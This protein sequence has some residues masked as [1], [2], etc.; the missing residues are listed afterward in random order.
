MSA[1]SKRARREEQK[2]SPLVKI[3]VGAATGVVLFFTL[4]SAISLATLKA[5]LGNEIYLPSG[6]A[7]GA[8]SG[9]A[10]GFVAVKPIK[11][12]AVPFGAAAGL[13]A[14]VISVAISAAISSAASLKLLALIGVMTLCSALGGILAVNMRKRSSY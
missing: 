11:K 7:A 6:L 2:A 8:L 5:G 9:F 4:I 14:S 12:N 10:A 1:K 3:S 13:A